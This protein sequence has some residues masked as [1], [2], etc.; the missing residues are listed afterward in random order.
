[1][2]K[3]KE[4][5]VLGTKYKVIMEKY[6]DNPKYKEDGLEGYEDCSVKEIHLCDLATRPPRANDLKD[7]KSTMNHVLAHE[8]VHAFM[9]ESGVTSAS[10]GHNEELVDWIAQ[11]LEALCGEYSKVKGK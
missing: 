8:L 11:H 3:V 6:D 4:V 7:R 2:G 9:D 5:T 10:W 1:M